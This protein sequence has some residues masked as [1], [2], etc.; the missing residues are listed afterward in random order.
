MD[1]EYHEASQ[2]RPLEHEITQLLDQLQR[3]LRGPLLSYR[4]EDM[5]ATVVRLIA[6]W[7]QYRRQREAIVAYAGADLC[8]VQ[9]PSG[10]AE[11]YWGASPTLASDTPRDHVELTCQAQIPAAHAPRPCGF[12]TTPH[13]TDLR[14]TVPEF[15]ALFDVARREDVEWGGRYDAR[16]AAINLWTQPWPQGCLSPLTGESTLV[17]TWY[18]QG[19]TAPC[20]WQI[21][22]DAEATLTDL[23]QELGGLELK[24]FWRLK[25]GAMPTGG[26]LPA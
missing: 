5:R 17:G 20:L 19:G 7:A 9:S 12:T 13:S 16:W 23:L 4:L 21:S 2:H 3:R 10:G 8:E 11:D 1:A 25:H 6:C 15:K 26:K 14:Y 24:A 18:F 22:T